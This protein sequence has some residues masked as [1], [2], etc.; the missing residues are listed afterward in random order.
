MIAI[1]MDRSAYALFIQDL[2]GH[3]EQVGFFLADYEP[4]KR[5]FKIRDWRVIGAAGFEYQSPYHVTLSD[6]TKVE[7][8]RWAWDSGASLVEAH[9][10]GGIHPAELSS[11]DVWGLREW[12][13]HL[14]WRL[15]ARPYAAIVTAG[16]DFDAVAWITAADQP[17]QVERIELD[18][19]STVPATALTLRVRKRQ[20]EEEQGHGEAVDRPLQP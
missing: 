2:Q 8:I 6:E 3:D 12:V 20:L 9:S 18:D 17:E 7:V 19:G 5:V 1:R 16:D 10:H 4:S 13:P 14:F 15:R 11:S